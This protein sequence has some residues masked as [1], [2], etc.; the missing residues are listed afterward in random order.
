MQSYGF[1]LDDFNLSDENVYNLISNYYENPTM[2]KFKNVDNLSMYIVIL[3]FNF[4]K[5]QRYLIVL[6]D[7]D[8][9]EL[10]QKFLLNKLKWRSFQS[11]VLEERFP[12][13]GV[14][15]YK[16]KNDS[17]YNS[18][19][20]MISSSPKIT[21]YVCPKFG[22]KISLLHVK[23]VKH[24]YPSSGTISSAL[25]TFQTIVNF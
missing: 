10:G 20:K 13:V 22:F 25:E 8:R 7:L 12:N 19:I 6:V 9:F 15:S 3:N 23:N 21:T 11:R 17:P 4:L 16:V 1:K 2:T 5:E 18:E 14:H 24:E